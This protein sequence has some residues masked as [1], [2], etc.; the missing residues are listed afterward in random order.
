MTLPLQKASA[1][2]SST[3]THA[4]GEVIVTAAKL[5]GN[6]DQV[7]IIMQGEGLENK[8]TSGWLGSKNKNKSDPY[9]EICRE[10][11]NHACELIVKTEVTASTASAPCGPR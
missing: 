6:Q 1:P 5:L 4:R 3:T 2:G 9:I 7:E 8:D 11:D 10:L